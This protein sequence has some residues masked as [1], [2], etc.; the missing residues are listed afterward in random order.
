M[1]TASEAL[2]SP[3]L[4]PAPISAGPISFITVRTSAKSGLIYPGRLIRSVIPLTAWTKT[5]SAIFI[6]STK[7]VCRWVR[8]RI[9]SLGIVIMVSTCFFSSS[10]PASAFFIRARPSKTNGF[11]TTA[12]VNAPS[13]LLTLAT[14]GAAPVP[15]PPPRPAVTKTMSLSLSDSLI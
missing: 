4:T 2:F 1:L 5:S 12:T 13:S 8:E 6:P 3:T 14:T 10:Q 15:V 11:V 7:V 9:L